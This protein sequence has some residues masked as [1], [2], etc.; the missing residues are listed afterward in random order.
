MRRMKECEYPFC[1][2][3]TLD[4]CTMSDK[5]LLRMRKR[6]AKGGDISENQCGDMDVVQEVFG[7]TPEG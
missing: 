2:R 3:C 4:D 7:E 1:D 6:R 5:D